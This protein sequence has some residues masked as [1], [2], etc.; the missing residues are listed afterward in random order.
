MGDAAGPSSNKGDGADIGIGM[1]GDADRQEG[2]EGK[3]D[4]TMPDKTNKTSILV[5]N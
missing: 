4:I 1:I 2:A 3:V 5:N